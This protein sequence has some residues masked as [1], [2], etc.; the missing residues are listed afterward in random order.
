MNILLSI[1]YLQVVHSSEMADSNSTEKYFVVV[2]V[3]CILFA[4]ITTYLISL[5]RRMRKMEKQKGE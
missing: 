4:L 2:T 1:L 5:D 3:I